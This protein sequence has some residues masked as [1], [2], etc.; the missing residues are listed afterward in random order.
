MTLFIT[1]FGGEGG[2]G[3]GGN[4]AGAPRDAAY[5]SFGGRN[6]RSKST[7]F[8]DRGSS[9]RGRWVELLHLTI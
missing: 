8:N 9:S 3:G 7:F 2:G 5:N 4:W 1:G 6:D